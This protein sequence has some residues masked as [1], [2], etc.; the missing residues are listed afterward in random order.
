MKITRRAAVVLACSA[1]VGFG[2]VSFVPAYGASGQAGQTQA[3]ATAATRTM[4]TVKAIA[5]N[6]LTVATDSGAE[7]KVEVAL[8]A[9]LLRM[10][11][12][13]KSLAGAAPLQFQEIQ[14]G[15]RMLVK[16]MASA[17][18]KVVVASLVVVMKKSDIAEKQTREREDWQKRGVGGRVSAIDPASGTI[19]VTTNGTNGNR[20]VTVH[21][22]TSTIV[23]R[24][25]ADSVKFDDAQL[26]KLEDIKEG[27]QLRARG[28]RTG[29]E[30]NAEEIVA[31]TFRNIAGIVSSTDA[32]KNEFT[33]SDLATK[34]P[35]VVKVTADSQLHKLP[36]MMAQAMA[37]RLK[38]G[39]PQ[40]N[41]QHGAEGGHAPAMANAAGPA[42]GA[43]ANGGPRGDVNQ[44]LS[45]L[46]ALTVADLQKGDAVMIV[47]TEGTEKEVT[48]INLLS[49]VEPILTASPTGDGSTVLSAWELN[50]GG[51]EGAGG[52]AP[53]Q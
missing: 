51:G 8:S 46:P 45:R 4:G 48:V 11:P 2:G 24:Y 38:G 29:A 30:M 39:A 27:D 15:D 19:T 36:P 26:A 7:I 25:A 50:A 20:V 3:S 16:G 37:M 13:Q 31:G 34:K 10:E 6:V 12:G 47:T 52:E 14:A 18:G 23:K 43:P 32:A 33:V 49:G 5:G 17:D 9:R 35:V 53:A 1:V 44:M 40:G 22:S 41:G 28:A 21:V 42:N